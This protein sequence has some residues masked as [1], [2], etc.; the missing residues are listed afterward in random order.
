MAE[1]ILMGEWS[2]YEAKALAT[3]QQ[4][5][6]VIE[7]KL[8]LSSDNLANPDKEAAVL[9]KME[10]YMISGMSIKATC[11]MVDGVLR[12]DALTHV[13]N[14][15]EVAEDLERQAAEWVEENGF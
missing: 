12:Y 2:S 13:A 1:E 9:C 7:A 11:E 14:I 15:R 6:V 4:P 10:L 8:V 5:C 3:W